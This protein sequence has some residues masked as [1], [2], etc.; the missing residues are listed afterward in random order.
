MFRAFACLVMVRSCAGSI[1]A[2][3][4]ANLLCRALLPKNRSPASALRSLQATTSR[5]RLAAR[6]PCRRDR[7][8]RLPLPLVQISEISSDLG[9]FLTHGVL[10]TRAA[11]DA[12]ATIPIVCFDCGD[13]VAT[14]LV[15]SLSQPGGNITGVTLVHPDMSGKR[16][17]LLKE[18][19]PGL[20]RVAVL[21][22]SSNPV[23]EP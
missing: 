5:R 20:A 17:E 3:R 23:A 16:L 12:S 13:L 6:L 18:M 11:R 14:G 15:E 22:N 1:I 8:H 2:L 21:Y 10:A 4:S 9:M 19:I 7:T